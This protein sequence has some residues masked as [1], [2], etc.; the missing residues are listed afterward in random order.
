MV[1][2]SS[3][4][5]IP[6]KNFKDEKENK[7]ERKRSQIEWWKRERMWCI[8]FQSFVSATTTTMM[9]ECHHPHDVHKSCTFYDSNLI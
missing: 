5:K 3:F 1:K 7:K 8:E 4:R 6:F 2:L 9:R